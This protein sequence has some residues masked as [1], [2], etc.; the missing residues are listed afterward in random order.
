MEP[1][2]PH[3]REGEN[4]NKTHRLGHQRSCGSRR[5][6][7]GSE[8]QL[9]GEEGLSAAVGIAA[10]E[11]SPAACWPR[12]SPH[13]PRLTSPNRVSED[14]VFLVHGGWCVVDPRE[15]V[16]PAWWR[17]ESCGLSGARVPLHRWAS[18]YNHF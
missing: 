17:R 9:R 2:G 18:L 4:S 10:C 15:G 16:G 11:C 5:D 3:G 8:P 7:S 14:P 12:P 13:S 6:A 1:A